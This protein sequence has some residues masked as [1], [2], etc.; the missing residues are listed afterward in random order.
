MSIEVIREAALTYVNAVTTA[1]KAGALN[2]YIDT[3]DKVRVQL[4]E[5]DDLF[6]SLPGDPETKRQSAEFDQQIK[7]VDGIEYFVLIEKTVN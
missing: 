6:D 4:S 3:K 7:T 5:Y 2:I 1:K